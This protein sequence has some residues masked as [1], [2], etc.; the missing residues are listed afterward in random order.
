MPGPW[1][2]LVRREETDDAGIVSPGHVQLPDE[3]IRAPC[4]ASKGTRVRPVPVAP[5]TG[6]AM[7]HRRP[8]PHRW[9]SGT[10]S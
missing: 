5:L 10:A 4:L 2:A 9:T 3:P 8:A 7:S 1:A 6:L